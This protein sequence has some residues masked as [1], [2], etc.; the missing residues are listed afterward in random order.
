MRSPTSPF[1]CLNRWKRARRRKIES[2]RL[3]KPGLARLRDLVPRHRANKSRRTL[4]RAGSLFCYFVAAVAGVVVVFLAGTRAGIGFA[5]GVGF[6]AV[7]GL[8]RRAALFTGLCAGAAATTGAAATG[9]RTV[10]ATPRRA[11]A[12]TPRPMA[13]PL[14]FGAIAV[15]VLPARAPCTGAPCA[16]TPTRIGVAELPPT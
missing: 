6:T 9:V 12:D 14:P 5:A 7:A 2:K 11:G 13:A 16:G 1:V 15:A 3:P 8:A 4:S 10:E